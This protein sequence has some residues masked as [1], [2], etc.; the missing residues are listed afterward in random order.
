LEKTLAE[1][2]MNKI[3]QLLDENFV[4]ELL[5][6]EVLP[7]QPEFTAIQRVEIKPYKQLIWETTY[8]VVIGFV[9][10]FL[11]KSGASKRW[12]IVCSAHSEEPRRNV[13]TALQYLWAIG[14]P[15]AANLVPEPL[16]YSEYFRGTFYRGLEGENFLHYIKHK[17]R[18]RIEDLT[19][20]SA[21][22]FAKLHS[23]R[24]QDTPPFDPV[25][26]RIATVVPGA[27]R[28]LEEM[29]NRYDNKYSQDLLAIYDYLISGENKYLDSQPELS[30]IHG[31]AHAENIIVVSEQQLGLIDFTD[32][33]LGDR[34]RDL[35]SFMQQLEYKIVNKVNDVAFATRMTELFLQTYLSATQTTLTPDLQAR[36]DLYYNWTAIRTATYWFLKAGHN[37]ER[38]IK[39]LQQVKNRLAL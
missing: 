20:R 21:G 39:L 3:N 30:L 1:K 27:Y 22:L 26:S 24:P 10:D 16:F 12:T 14:F 35:G 25:N 34:A 5:R 32:L 6:Q 29:G 13:Y 2:Y 17:D 18:Q 7:Q 11:T 28:I 38:G 23:L 15:D 37:E 19:R 31:D 4:L 33:C 8:H 36:I 9:V